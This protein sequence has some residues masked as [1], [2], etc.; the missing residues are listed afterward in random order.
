LAKR[1]LVVDD[2]PAVALALK[3]VFRVDGRFEIAGSAQT[4]ADGLRLPAG[5]ADAILLD[6]HLPDMSGVQLVQAFREQRPDVPLILHSAADETPE[7]GEVRE[8]VDAV[9]LKSQVD[10]LLSTLARLTEA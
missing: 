4:A 6:L 9:V 8:L 1:V 5:G 3:V 2:H 10:E 7:I